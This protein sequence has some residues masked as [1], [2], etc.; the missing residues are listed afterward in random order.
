MSELTTAGLVVGVEAESAIKIIRVQARGRKKW[1]S[2][3][4]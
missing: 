3:R 1:K 2:P 4:K